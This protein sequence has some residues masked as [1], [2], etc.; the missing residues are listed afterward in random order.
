MNT[1]PE[2]IK[3]S[4]TKKIFKFFSWF[5][6]STFLILSTLLLL[7]YLY[8]DDIKNAIIKE[9]NTHLKT[10][11]KV[12]PENIDITFIST[13]PYCSLQFSDVLVYEVNSKNK[14]DTLLHS[15]KI[16]LFFNAKDIWNKNYTIN[17][18]LLENSTCNLKLFK[19]GKNNY[20]IWKTD[21]LKSNTSDVKFALN[22]ILIKNSKFKFSN[23]LNNLKSSFNLN[24]INFKG[25]FENENYV[26]ESEFDLKIL[27]LISN[28]KNYIKNKTCKGEIK[29]NVNKNLYQIS[30][31]SVAMNKVLMAVNGSFNYNDSIYQTNLNFE[32][33]NLDIESVLSLLPENHKK[34]INDY[35][36]SGKFYVNGKIDYS[37]SKKY[38]FN[39]DFG[40]NNAIVTYKPNQINLSKLNLIGNIIYSNSS[41]SLKLNNLNALLVND[42]IS[43]N[44][45]I[46]NFSNP[47]IE[48]Q[49][50]ANVNLKNAIK[51]WPIDTITDIAGLLKIN[52][53][54]KGNLNQIKTN[55]TNNDIVLNLNCSLKDALIKFKNNQNQTQIVSCDLMAKERNIFVQ[56]LKLTKGK[57]DLTINGELPNFFKYLFEKNIDLNIIGELNSNQLYLDDFFDKQSSSASKNDVNKSIIP[58]NLNF[59]L[60][61]NINQFYYQKFEAKKIY[62]EL[63]IKHQ[64]AI[65][66]DFKMEAFQGEVNG[67]LFIDNSK[68]NLQV[69]S[70]GLFKSVNIQT[71]FTQFD[72]FGQETLIDKNIKGYATATVSFKA[73]W[74]NN[75]NVNEKS[76]TAHTDLFIERGELID[77]KPLESLSKYVD[78]AELKRIKF[79]SLETTVDIKDQIIQ[80]P[81]TQINNNVLN[82]LASGKHTFNNEIDYR[83]QLKISELLAKKR[84]QDNEFGPVE[85][86]KDNKR[87]AFIVMTGTVDD[88]IIKYDKNGLKE[89]IKQDLKDEKQTLKNILREEF[90]LFK[91]D[92]VKQDN[93]KSN[94]TFEL[95]KTKTNKHKEQQNNETEDDDF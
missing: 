22:N 76:I 20:E 40:I 39:C 42:S 47:T 85:N 52:G 1:E 17:K 32:A 72:N 89:K 7:I 68:N 18:I 28:K 35:E 49:F 24:Q 53:F 84:K 57:S 2:K 59:K 77:F 79:S 26:L 62:G 45:L 93:K 91:K 37:N 80:F 56:N 11:V 6:I 48:T 75:F 44:L 83:I 46:N 36:S 69:T 13:F 95:E 61:A 78:I 14:P 94:Q 88:P 41:S 19:N 34:S 55:I 58:N 29:F 31:A 50:K 27:N 70:V 66:S 33:Q 15:E 63:E 10:E 82:I 8:Q 5:I 23:Q 12:K 16:N 30:K 87:S 71:L 65:L 67:D 60:L 74:D 73:D 9:I 54:L 21:T 25:E 3:K 64:K 4:I 86:D 51:F 81:K 38:S 43:G 92:S 90:K